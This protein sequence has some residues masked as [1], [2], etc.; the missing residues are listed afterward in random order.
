MSYI[1]SGLGVMIGI[2]VTPAG[3][4]LGGTRG[5]DIR[6]CFYLEHDSLKLPFPHRQP[7]PVSCLS[8]EVSVRLSVEEFRLHFMKS[9][10]CLLFGT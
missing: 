3:N 1:V 9:I 10:Q 6:G 8:S 4:T 5:L 2:G 7:S